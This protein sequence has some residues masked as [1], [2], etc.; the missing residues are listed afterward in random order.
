MYCPLKFN[1][2]PEATPGHSILIDENLW[3]CE[4]TDCEWYNQ[5][6]G[7]CSLYLLALTIDERVELERKGV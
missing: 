6:Y 2:R 3:Q 4:G 5:E 1:I 7:K